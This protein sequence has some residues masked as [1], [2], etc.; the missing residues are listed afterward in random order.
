LK[1]SNKVDSENDQEGA[2]SSN[3]EEGAL[4]EADSVMAPVSSQVQNDYSISFKGPGLNSTIL[5]SELDDLIIVEAILAKVRKK[6]EVD[7]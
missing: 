1:D 6:L 4:A 5:I 7:L 3:E 2:Q